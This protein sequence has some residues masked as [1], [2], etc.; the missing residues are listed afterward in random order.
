M[1]SSSQFLPC[2]ENRAGCAGSAVASGDRR[3]RSNGVG[4][5]GGATPAGSAACQAWQVAPQETALG[6]GGRPSEAP[7]REHGGATPAACAAGQRH[8]DVGG[9]WPALRQA[10][11]Y[12]GLTTPQE[13]PAR[14][15]QR[16]R[17]LASVWEI[18]RLH[19]FRSNRRLL[20]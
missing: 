16:S 3:T 1:Q 4:H 20:V 7:A 17:P 11:W 12:A 2:R 6:H 13:A 10:R 19:S 14:G 5:G 9:A 18:L 15:A 8:G